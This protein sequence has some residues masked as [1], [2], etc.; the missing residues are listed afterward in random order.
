MNAA[1]W[2][3]VKFGL[4]VTGQ[5]ESDFLSELFRGIAASGRCHFR[6]IHTVGQ[7]VPISEKQQRAYREHGKIIPDRDAEIGAKIRRWLVDSSDHSAIW[8]DDLES[9]ER[10]AAAEKFARLRKTAEEMLSR[11]PEQLKRFSVHFLVNMLEAY[12]F[13]QT[14]AVNAVLGTDLH[15]H[16]GDCENIVHPKNELK[17][18]ANQ[19]G[20]AFDERSNGA[21]IVPKLDLDHILSNPQTCRALRTLVAWCWQ[22]IGEPRSDKFRLAD[23]VYWDITAAQLSD[24]PPAEQRGP[25]AAEESYQPLQN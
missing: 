8:I 13:A 22:A 3:F 2:R 5:G 1:T 4:V 6:V 17:R 10:S 14:E 25:L 18:L 7:R 16:A 23:G 24:L 19:A 15:D 12:Y 20:V 9:S 21:E 11:M